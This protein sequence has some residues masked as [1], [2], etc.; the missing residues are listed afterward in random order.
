MPG[1]EI[2]LSRG[3]GMETLLQDLRFGFR[4]LWKRPGFTIA[5]V[6]CIA[7]G[8]GANSATFSFANAFL[9]RKS[10][11]AEPDRLVRIFVEWQ[12]GLKY[13]SFSYP[14]YSDVRDKND[15]FAGLV[16]SSIMPMHLSAGDRSERVWGA[17]VSGNYFAALGIK[18][19]LGR[20]FEPEEDKNPGS[21][22]VA[23]IGHGLWQRRF[24]ADPAVVGRTL[25]LNTLP[26]TVIGIAPPG[27]Y[28]MDTGVGQEVWIPLMMTGQMGDQRRSMTARGSHWVQSVIGRLKPGITM[29]QAGASMSSLMANLASEYPT[30]NKNK[31]ARLYSLA[32]TSLHPMVR[33]G[34]VQFL[35][36]MFGV[37]GFILLLACSNVAGLLLARSSARRREISV[38][39]ALGAGRMRLIRQ[40]LA[41][42]ILLSFLAGGVGILLNV[43]LT[44]LIQSFTPPSDLPLRIDVGLDWPVLGF[45]FAVTA[46]TGMLFGLTPALA[47]TRTDL[48]SV[49]KEGSPVHLGGASRLRRALVVGQVALSLSLL[50]GAGLL[51][52]S[53]QAARD[54]DPGFNPDHQLVAAMN[55]GLQ[56]YDEAKGRQFVQSLRNRMQGLPGVQ[57]VGFSD[58][59]P[60]SLSSSQTSVRPEGFTAPPDSSLPA[61][62]YCTVDYGYFQ[63]MG[64]PI[65]R[66]RGFLETDKVDSPPV[67]VINEAFAQRF[68]PGQDPIG[69]RV[70]TGGKD[71]QVIGVVKTG[72]YFSLGE[73]P[74]SFFYF[75]LEQNHRASVFLHVRT[76]TDPDSLLETVRREVRVLDDKLPLSDL[77]T[78]HA[79]MGFALLPA[80]MAAGVVSAFA[81]L[82]LFL[83][84]IGLYG[85]ISFSVT[86]SMRDIGIR[87]ALGAQAGDVLKLVIRG[88]MTLTAIGLVLG[89]GLSIALTRLVKS[90]LYG[91]SATD[92]LSYAVAVTILAL[93]TFLAVYLPARRATRVD[94]IIALR[95]V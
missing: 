92:P 57:S 20:A 90:L 41:E 43:W 59:L 1:A 89:L 25:S 53:L 16:A 33:G 48:V 51:V 87:M 83:A 5:A 74:K 18:P 17:V 19:I 26:F 91:L 67:I 81:F 44:Q 29:E 76:S 39:M 71:Q 82:A 73:D 32:E 46:V 38:R 86:Q 80:R 8:I 11:A 56:R 78:M 79:A 4:Q 69:K 22:P 95:E 6:L 49:L 42:S 15:V 40:L 66:G 60:L 35:K 64:I 47:A 9:W 58:S 28:G 30:T 50:I 72:K 24:G 27:F 63:A 54:L 65:R 12:A 77:R 36:L 23:V 2:H 75:P 84:A 70:R 10:M 93:V 85:V 68:W 34:F 62:D 55:L 21:H 52:R 13:G 7:L 37:V 88:G 3:N 31:G 94:P 14:D 45:T 61:I